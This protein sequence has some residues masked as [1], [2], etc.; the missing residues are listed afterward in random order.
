MED[1]KK[2]CLF[3]CAR[4]P[5]KAKDYVKR[6]SED[7][8]DSATDL[9]DKS[10]QAIARQKEQLAAAVEAGRSAY[11]EK[12]EAVTPLTDQGDEIIEGV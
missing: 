9:L 12:V 2:F 6:R 11:R 5:T 4:R 8:K 1:D 7:L 10:K 3:F